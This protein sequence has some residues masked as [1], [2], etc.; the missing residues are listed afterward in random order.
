MN[1]ILREEKSEQGREPTGFLEGKTIY[2][3]FVWKTTTV[4]YQTNNG[5]MVLN[6]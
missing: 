6:E 5:H 3:N 2:L 4:Q 1:K